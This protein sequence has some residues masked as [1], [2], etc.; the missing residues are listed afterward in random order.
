MSDKIWRTKIEVVVYSRDSLKEPPGEDEYGFSFLGWV[1]EEI[2]TGDKIG[3]YNVTSEEQITMEEARKELI[4][5]GND[6]D[7][8][9]DDME[10]DD[11][12]RN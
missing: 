8:F 7:F 10:D 6:G 4:E 9:D 11:D 1:A 2:D 3:D 5:I 12:G